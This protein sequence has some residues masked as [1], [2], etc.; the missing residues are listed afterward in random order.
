MQSGTFARGCP[1][2]QYKW[3]YS[4]SKRNIGQELFNAFEKNV[5]FD[6]RRV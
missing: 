4:N 2:G 6:S 3:R 5:G 1:L